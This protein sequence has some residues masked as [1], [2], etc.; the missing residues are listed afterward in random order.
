MQRR[1]R[2]P[3][4]PDFGRALRHVRLER[5]LAQEQFDLISSRTYISSLERGLKFPTLPKVDAIAEVLGVHPLTLIALSFVDPAVAGADDIQRLLQRVESEA[6][7]L[8]PRL[9]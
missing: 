1:Q 5:K 8:L 7:T 2:A 3:T 4:V 9:R 6:N